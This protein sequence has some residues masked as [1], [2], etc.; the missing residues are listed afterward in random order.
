MNEG[1]VAPI[2]GGVAFLIV[3]AA[4]S[5]RIAQ[6]YQRAV[7][8]RLGKLQGIRGP[9]LYWLIPAIETQQT[10]DIRTITTSEAYALASAPVPG[11]EQD[12]RLF[13]HQM[14]RP[15]TAHQLADA[16]AQAT[17]TEL[18]FDI[19]RGGGGLLETRK[20]VEVSDPSIP[21]VLLDTFGRCPR[22]SGCAPV[23]NPAL[24]LRQS[25]LLI[26]GSVIDDRITALFK[27]LGVDP[28]RVSP[29]TFAELGEI[30]RIVVQGMIEVLQSRTEVKNNFRVPM[31]TMRP[32]E[33]N[34]LKEGRPR[35]S[36]PFVTRYVG[37]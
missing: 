16:L 3:L 8:F 9:G 30:L 4:L 6:E 12:R 14:P 35:Q 21:N 20:A 33:N 2:V 37:V 5:V 32:V 23:A 11:N 36:W 18:R 34:P 25:L 1:I 10:I 24:S 13:S 28:D 22:T 31:T 26:G 15:L 7:V 19:S 17:D 27:G 29:E